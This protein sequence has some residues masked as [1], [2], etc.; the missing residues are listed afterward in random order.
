M[1]RKLKILILLPVL[2]YLSGCNN[3]EVEIRLLG[4][5][6]INIVQYD[7]FIDPGYEVYIGDDITE[8][9]EQNF[10]IIGEIDTTSLGTQTLTYTYTTENDETHTIIRT[11]HIVLLSELHNC[12]TFE[13][14]SI[15]ISYDSIQTIVTVSENDLTLKEAKLYLLVDGIPLQSESLSKGS[16][17][18]TFDNLLPNKNYIM[19]IRYTDVYNNKEYQQ[20]IPYYSFTT[21]EI[22]SFEYNVSMIQYDVTALSLKVTVTRG[23]FEGTIDLYLDDT[24]I[25]SIEATSGVNEITFNNLYPDS[26]YKVYF[27]YVYQDNSD[28]VTQKDLLINHNTD[29]LRQPIL[30]LDNYSITSSSLTLD[31]TAFEGDFQVYNYIINLYT[32]EEVEYLNL[33]TAPTTIIFD[34]LEPNTEYTVYI[35]VSYL[36]GMDIKDEVA[37]TDTFTTENN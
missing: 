17:R 3:T 16:N 36:G 25:E 27:N 24:F 20:I 35:R 34:E 4:Q 19:E 11:I 13:Q 21:L 28:E 10:M 26:S 7:E 1:K 31:F 8:L 12:T 33:N 2:L 22:P 30:H 15:D 5:N 18:I 37:Y 14:E 29:I 9:T 32:S 23:D 6:T